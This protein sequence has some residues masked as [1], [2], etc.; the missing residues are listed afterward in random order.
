[1]V[2]QPI[3]QAIAQPDHSSVTI[4]SD[5]IFAISRR[6]WLDVHCA[7]TAGSASS[8]SRFGYGHGHYVARPGSLPT[9]AALVRKI[10]GTIDGTE[11]V[12]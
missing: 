6:S 4:S 2:F 3:R 5:R 7:Q 10:F 1:M 8:Q 11:S 12:P 9:W